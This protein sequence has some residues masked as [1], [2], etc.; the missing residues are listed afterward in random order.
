M[1]SRERV[2]GSVRHQEP[3]RIPI[4]LGSTPSSGISAI[5]YNNLKKHLNMRDGHTRV[6]DVCQQVAQPEDEIIERF[7][8]DVIDIGR[9]FNTYDEDWHEISLSDGSKAEYPK[10]VQACHSTRR[11][12]YRLS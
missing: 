1:T 7:G 11:K 9:K 12:L 2:V 4:D 3:D 10:L 5:A 6:Y 8:I